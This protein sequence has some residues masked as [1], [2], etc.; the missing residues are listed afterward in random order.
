MKYSEEELRQA[1]RLKR[2]AELYKA[3]ERME[4]A[5]QELDKS[6]SKLQFGENSNENF[7]SYYRFVQ[8]VSKNIEFLRTTIKLSRS[9]LQGYRQVDNPKFIGKSIWSSSSSSKSSKSTPFD[10]LDKRVGDLEFKV[11]LIIGMFVAIFVSLF[12]NILFS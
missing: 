4:L 7:D 5:F 10:Y 12:V 2:L 11:N 1:E 9:S 3:L 6:S 8:P